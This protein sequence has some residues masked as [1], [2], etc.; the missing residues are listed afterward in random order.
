MPEQHFAK[1]DR[2]A[3]IV[4]SHVAL[5]QCPILRAVRDEPLVPED[6]GWQFL[7]GLVGEEDPA[8]AKVWLVMEVVGY[9]GS[10]A[11]FIESP[12]GTVL[13]RPDAFSHW[14]VNRGEKRA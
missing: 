4:C 2:R 1:Q 11:Q 14:T 9:D 3:A 7:C 13:T 5:G 12:P 10:L 8:S 6:S